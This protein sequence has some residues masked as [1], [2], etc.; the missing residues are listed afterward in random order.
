MH[1]YFTKLAIFSRRA[2]A[3]VLLILINSAFILAQECIELSDFDDSEKGIINWSQF[4]DFTLPFEMIYGPP[5]QNGDFTSPLTHGFNHV[6]DQNHVKSVPLNQ[7]AQIYYGTAYAN[8]NQPWEILRSPWGNNIDLYSNKWLADF[9]T[10]AGGSG[11]PN[12]IDPNYFCFDIERTFRFDYEILQLKNN[13]QIPQEYRNLS[14]QD[15][16]KRYKKDLRDLYAL[17]V[18]STLAPGLSNQTRIGSYAD[19][20][21]VNTFQNIQGRTWEQWKTDKKALNYICT[22][23]NG[24]LGGPFYNQ[25]D[26]D[27]PS[28]YYYYDYPHP[29]AGEYLSYML[30]QIE[31]NKAWSNKPVIPFVWM[32]YS[33]N[34]DVVNTYIRPWMAEATAIFPFFSGAD[35][36]WLWE[37]PF[38]F[39]E[40]SSFATYS[41]YLKGLYRL[42]QVKRFFEGEHELIIETSARDYNENKQPIWRGVVKGNEILIAAHNPFATENEEVTIGVSYNNWSSTV[43]LNGY[44]T[45]LCVFDMSILGTENEERTISVYPNPVN[46]ILKIK[47]EQ[48]TE[49]EVLVNLN[50][51]SGVRLLSKKVNVPEETLEFEIDISNITVPSFLV[52]VIYGEK[53]FIRK[54]VKN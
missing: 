49:S 16:L 25:M 4:P 40:E 44:E 38:L 7:S 10:F 17:S 28:T 30:F 29:F 43:T 19:T 33:F 54:I 52:E 14:D 24:N 45:K 6:V 42:S 48:K 12:L 35:G 41:H 50:S 1:F 2:W 18:S 26:V 34:V 5:L 31:A 8:A 11:N 13:A 46:E 32:R 9:N 15:F 39:Y 51:V 27:M 22:D 21:I 37:D 23:D 36:V 47:L 3:V 53:R 20:P